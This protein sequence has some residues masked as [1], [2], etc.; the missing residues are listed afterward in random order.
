MKAIPSYGKVM[1]L[2]NPGTEN[3]LNGHL[4][5]Q[6]KV[7][8]SQF[9]FG[10]TEDGELTIR[11]KG[12]VI[13]EQCDN[14][15]QEGWEY[16]Y[17]I[18]DKILKYGPDVYFYCEYMKRPKHNVLKYE[19]IPKNHIVL[20]DCLKQGKWVDRQTLEFIAKDLD[21]DVV[22]QIYIG[23]IEAKR[24]EVGHGGYKSTAIDFIKRLLAITPSFL[25]GEMIEGIV[26]K[27]YNQ[28]ITLNGKVMP[29]FTKY[30]QEKFREKHEVEWRDK[31][32]KGQ[33]QQFIE[34]FQSD[35]RWDKAWQHLRDEGKLQNML[36][37]IPK[38]VGEVH[39]DLMEEEAQY[40]KDHLYKCYIDD[41]KRTA[42]R[43]LAEWYKEKLLKN[44]K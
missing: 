44:V 33:L 8:G 11:S 18:K 29:L 12:K 42:V 20:F 25:G 41:I 40:I 28:F 1:N 7:D 13:T 5:V 17:S 36:Q 31:K 35:A 38:L 43:G 32:P 2:G 22:P 16:I 23:E 6:E 39:R 21:V 15:F 27:N 37:D 14:L 30:V 19:R 34:G 3:A 24:R 9:G 26:I 10:V 4:I